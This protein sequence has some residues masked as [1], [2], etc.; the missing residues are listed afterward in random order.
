M[1]NK[2]SV[3]HTILNTVGFDK[4][5]LALSRIFDAQPHLRNEEVHNTYGIAL[6]YIQR[7]IS[8]KELTD[9]LTLQSVQV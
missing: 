8:F 3:V 2:V 7:K 4:E 5:R 9:A 1:S 6:Q